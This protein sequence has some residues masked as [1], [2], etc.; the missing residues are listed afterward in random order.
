MTDNSVSF[1][2]E[3]G[4][5]VDGA[6]RVLG[7]RLARRLG[8]ASRVEVDELE[9][10]RARIIAAADAQRRRIERDLHDGAQQHLVALA[11]N[12]QVAR[13]LAD[14]DP[15]AAKALLEEIAA[16][17]RE[18]LESVRELAQGIYPPLLL[19]R[20]LAEALR[21]AAS[22]AGVSARVEAPA[23]RYPPDVE[24][25]AYFCCLEALRNAAEHAGAGA[26]ATVHAWHEQAALHFEVVDDGVG[27]EQSVTRWGAG[28]SSI[29]DR[30]GALGGRLTLSSEPGK[31]TRVSGTIPLAP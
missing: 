20:G 14:S 3:G 21:A 5:T 25:A 12:L 16:D 17:V 30:L 26:R 18:A 31:G 19:D 8:L 15:D 24:A 13:Q 10:S 9:A 2:D 11:V 27:F 29:S 23:D 4:V 1:N 7:S 22:G 28:L 6:P